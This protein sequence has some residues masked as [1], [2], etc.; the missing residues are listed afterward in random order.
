MVTRQETGYGT[1]L[2]LSDYQGH[3]AIASLRLH[4]QLPGSS[5]ATMQPATESDHCRLSATCISA[6]LQ[7]VTFQTDV[8]QLQTAGCGYSPDRLK[9]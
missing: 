3:E 7:T 1:G 9:C 4:Q 6:S 2:S 8:R 5:D